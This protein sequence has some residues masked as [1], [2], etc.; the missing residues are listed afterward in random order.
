MT[1]QTKTVRVI[2][3]VGQSLLGLSFNLGG[4]LAGALLTVYFKIFSLAPWVIVLYP[5]ILSMRG[6]IGGVFSG[7]LSTGLHLGTV[8]PKFI[9]NTRDF[10]LLFSS[11]VALTLESSILIGFSAFVF[12]LLLWNASLTSLFEILSVIVGTMSLSLLFISR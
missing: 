10:Y 2:E 7:R 11:V 6:A 5:C 4:M 3:A 1:V 12:G 8:N 9:G